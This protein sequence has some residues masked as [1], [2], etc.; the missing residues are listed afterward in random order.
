MTISA[1]VREDLVTDAGGEITNA[2]PASAAGGCI[3][4][5]GAVGRDVLRIN[6]L[7]RTKARYRDR[8]DG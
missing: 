7:T 4:R 5:V 3:P 1:E 8:G 2:E 6:A